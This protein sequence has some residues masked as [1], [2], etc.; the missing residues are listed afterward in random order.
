M[1]PSV[2]YLISTTFCIG[3]L[4]STS[5]ITETLYVTTIPTVVK[6]GCSETPLPYCNKAEFL[7]DDNFFGP[8]FT[9]DRMKE[10]PTSSAVEVITEDTHDAVE[11]ISKATTVEKTASDTMQPVSTAPITMTTVAGSITLLF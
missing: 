9:F 6:T 2:L 5:I 7:F 8:D 11:T 10:S 4:A 1:G 3:V